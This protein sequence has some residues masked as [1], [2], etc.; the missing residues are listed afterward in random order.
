MKLIINFTKDLNNSNE[1]VKFADLE[2]FLG[3]KKLI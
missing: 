2:L 1:E 3:F